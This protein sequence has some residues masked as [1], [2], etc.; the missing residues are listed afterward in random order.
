MHPTYPR[1]TS[2]WLRPWPIAFACMAVVAAA[3]I[4]SNSLSQFASGVVHGA[5]QSHAVVLPSFHVKPPPEAVCGNPRVLAG[6]ASP[7]ASAVVVPAGDDSAVNFGTPGATYWFAPGRHVLGAGEYTQITPGDG[8]TFTGAP[9]AVIDGKHLN[10]YAFGGSASHV[11]ISFL[12]IEDFGS[13]GGNLNQGVVNHN[14][15]SYWT[16]EHA[17]VRDNAGAGVMLGSHNTLSYDC[18]ADNQQYGF[19]AYTPDSVIADLMIDHNE[20]SGNDTFNWEARQPGCGCSGGGKFWEVDGAVVTDN[21]VSNNGS[22]GLWADTDNRGFEIVGNYISGNY[23]NGL[24]YEISYNAYIS[25]NTFVRN[26][27]GAGPQSVSFP[28]SAL[29]ISESGGDTRVPGKYSGELEV[30]DNTFVNN[31]SGVILWENANRF[32][33]SPANTSTGYCTLVNPGQI[34]LTSCNSTNIDKKPYIGDC[35]WKT[36]NV[37]VDHNVFDFNEAAVGSSCSAATGCGYQGIFSEYGTYPSWSPYQKTVVE[38]AI[39]YQQDNRFFANVYNGPWQF[40]IYQQGN[41]VSWK[42]WTSAPDRQDAGSTAGSYA[43]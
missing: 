28:T 34:A 41:V 36:Q 38:Q 18:L 13:P 8:A 25:G 17:T 20:I 10:A 27:I 2:R 26:G 31:W 43:G 12:T 7:P 33:N 4:F 19:N 35:R 6:P 22:V 9:G 39:T 15:A 21:W 32:C 23:S 5:Q 14:S 1:Y 24:I 37:S 3:L 11:T 30:T 42:T 16:I 40:M 29:Y